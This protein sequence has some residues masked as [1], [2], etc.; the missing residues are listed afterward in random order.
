[1]WTSYPCI[2][3]AKIKGGGSHKSYNILD[4]RVI[5]WIFHKS[6]SKEFHPHFNIKLHT[7]RISHDLFIGKSSKKTSNSMCDPLLRNFV[8]NP[9][10]RQQNPILHEEDAKRRR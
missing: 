2:G 3:Q 6:R 10:Q 8:E 1:M 5:S 4:L 7:T 9:P